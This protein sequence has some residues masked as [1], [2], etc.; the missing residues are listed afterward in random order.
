M[1]DLLTQPMLLIPLTTVVL[2]IFA[3]GYIYTMVQNNK[4]IIA[5]QQS[6]M[7]EIQKREQRY[8]ALFENSAAGMMKFDLLT[9]EI[10]EA[11]ET[12]RNMF[13]CTTNA[14]LQN[15]FSEILTEDFYGIEQLL[16]MQGYVDAIEIQY[17][18]AKDIVRRYLF[19]ARKEPHGNSAA[20]VIVYITAQRLLG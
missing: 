17:T 9:F 7:E 15:I 8:K 6:K 10:L 2:L 5:E 18:T 12:L 11:N 3:A 1:Q 4:K 13:S 19:S 16:K 14:E 20:A